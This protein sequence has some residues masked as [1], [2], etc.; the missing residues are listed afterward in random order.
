MTCSFWGG[1]YKKF[2][3]WGISDAMFFSFPL[4][5]VNFMSFANNELS[6]CPYEIQKF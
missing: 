3:I 2:L 1:F 6:F 5:F 4:S